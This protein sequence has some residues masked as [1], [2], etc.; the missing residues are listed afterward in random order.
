[1]PDRVNGEEIARQVDAM[2]A[3]A[4]D[5]SLRLAAVARFREQLAELADSVA[6]LADDAARRHLTDRIADLLKRLS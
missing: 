2:N 5:R 4:N 1:M 3:G 6:W